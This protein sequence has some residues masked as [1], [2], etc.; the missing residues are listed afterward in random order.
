MDFK[1]KQ[2][3]F[4]E[5]ME[6][7]KDYLSEA[8]QK[9]TNANT[10]LVNLINMGYSPDGQLEEIGSHIDKSLEEEDTAYYRILDLPGLDD[11]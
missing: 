6:K 8:D 10:E 11:E 7:I 3:F 2:R 4:E 9:L 1:E 5:K